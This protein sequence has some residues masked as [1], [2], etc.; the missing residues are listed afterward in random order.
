M[1]R[2][3]QWIAAA[4]I[5]VTGAGAASADDHPV[6]VE[7]YTSQGCSS[8]PPADAL[9]HKLADRDDVIALALHVDYWDY[10]GWKDSFADPAF[11]ARQ[12]SWARAHNKRTVYTP[13]MIVHG[14]EDVVGTHP[15][16]LAKTIDAHGDQPGRVSLDVSRS[17]ETV[18]VR[19]EPD[20]GLPR[21]VLQLVRYRP[22]ATVEILRGENAGKTLSYANI[23]TEWT[24]LAE[25]D[26]R[27]PL[28]IEAQVTGD[29]PVVFIL[30]EKGY[31][32][33]LSAAR[34]R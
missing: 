5:A 34:L 11:T 21:S 1:T 20:R 15:M 31:G 22:Q 7:L 24:A 32:P 14:A 27:V 25:W 23:V 2:F 28:E 17:G 19:A 30:Q 6:V 10:I 3:L 33:V 26:G 29:Q 8:C 9:L 12:K 16:D 13:Q 4:A 18:T